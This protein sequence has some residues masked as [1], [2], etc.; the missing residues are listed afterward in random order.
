VPRSLP[1]RE[2]GDPYA[3]LVSGVILQ[4][5]QALRVVP[6]Y[7]RWLARFRTW[8]RC[9]RGCERAVGFTPDARP[10][11]MNGFVEEEHFPVEDRAR[12]RCSARQN[13]RTARCPIGRDGVDVREPRRQAFEQEASRA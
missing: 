5:T 9:P 6:Y 4:Q 7:E 3:L 13:T 11:E 10:T 8:V 12:E 2:T 1:W